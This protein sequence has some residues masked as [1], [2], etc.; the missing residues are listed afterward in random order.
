MWLF[1]KNEPTGEPASDEAI[2][3]AYRKSGDKQLFA[4]LFKAHVTA[5]YGT[6]MFYLEDKEEAKDAV[7]Q[8]FEK[9]MAELRGNEVKNFKAWL[10]FVVRN[11]CISLIRKRNTAL[12]NNKSYYEF[13]YSEPSYDE[14]LR[15]SAV[16]H[17]RMM[18]H[19]MECLP[20]LKESQRK[21]V[22]L[23]YLQGLSYQQ[24]SEST[25]YS[26]NEVKSFIQ[27][28]KRNLKLMLEEKQ[29]SHNP[30]E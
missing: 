7:M 27:N 23:F 21:C 6:C 3:L 14:E 30:N 5:V 9:L 20:K 25:T 13:E 15:I 22:E 16:G 28:G 1:R 8:I 10:G 29:R 26:V 24:I 2:C 12:K 18:Q 11:H 19:M 4:G 17:E